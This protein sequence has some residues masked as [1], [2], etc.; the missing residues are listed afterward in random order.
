MFVGL[1]V[2][3]ATLAAMMLANMLRAGGL[4]APPANQPLPQSYMPIEVPVRYRF[5]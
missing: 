5:G 3:L 2:G 4:K 1:L